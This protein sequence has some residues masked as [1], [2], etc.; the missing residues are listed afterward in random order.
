MDQIA[1]AAGLSRQALYLHFKSKTDL[2][3]ALLDEIGDRY[4]LPARIGRVFTASTSV[5]AL[6]ELVSMH[7]AYDSR[8]Y[9]VARI[10]RGVRREEQATGAAW[11]DRMTR[12]RL[13]YRRVVEW[14]A[15]DDM[16]DEALTTDDATD[17]V[18][19][20]L[21]P[22]FYEY[23]AV[24]AGWAPDHYEAQVRTLLHRTLLRR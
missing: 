12:R 14:L 16:L 15:N 11:A 17:L 20:L 9:E 21:S 10:L 5:E 8:I 23:L 13:G 19:S 1:A 2:L 7:I 24:D 4:G 18:W 22:D 6:N 3:L